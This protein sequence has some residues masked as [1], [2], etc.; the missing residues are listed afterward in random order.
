MKK[1][2]PNTTISRDWSS[3][4]LLLKEAVWANAGGDSAELRLTSAFASYGRC[5]ALGRQTARLMPALRWHRQRRRL[6]R[7]LRCLP[8]GYPGG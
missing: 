8:R 5:D 1:A 2:M 6:H 3:A 7:P 4:S